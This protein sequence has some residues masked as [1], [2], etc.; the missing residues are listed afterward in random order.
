MDE[1]ATK[2][3][4]PAVQPALSPPDPNA[5]APSPREW[6]RWAQGFSFIFWGLFA[7]LFTLAETLGASALLY[8][9]VSPGFDSIHGMM[10]NIYSSVVGCAGALGVVVGSWRLYQTRG[11]GRLWRICT[12]G[13]LIGSVLI[14][15]LF[16]FFCFWR[17][18][19]TSLYF[20]GHSIGWGTALILE[21]SLLCFA[22]GALAR[23]LGRSSMATQSVLYGLITL[24]VLLTPFFTLAWRLVW[25][26][27]HQ[28]DPLIALE[29]IMSNLPP[30]AV[31][32]VLAPIALTLSLAWSAKDIAL[33]QLTGTQT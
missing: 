10:L 2:S 7:L 28:G 31:L 4:E 9:R 8:Y 26:A 19:P 25:I 3:W 27:R 18:V 20:L 30:L 12:L 32:F 16:P 15:Y 13:L 29:F 17:Q 6:A 1:A 5:V 21:M 14:A 24:I 23:V 33:R 11:Q 22:I